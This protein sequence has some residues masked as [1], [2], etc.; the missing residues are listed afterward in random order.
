MINH[1]LYIGWQNSYLLSHPNATLAPQA[2]QAK[3]SGEILNY[4][5]QAQQARLSGQIEL[6]AESLFLHPKVIS[7]LAP[8]SHQLLLILPGQEFSKLSAMVQLVLNSFP[9]IWTTRRDHWRRWRSSTGHTWQQ[10]ETRS[11]SRARTV[12][13]STYSGEIVILKS[14]TDCYHF[15]FRP[16]NISLETAQPNAGKGKQSKLW[17]YFS[18]ILISTICKTMLLQ[19]QFGIFIILC[20]I[21]NLASKSVSRR[22]TWTFDKTLPVKS[23]SESWGCEAGDIS[24]LAVLVFVHGESWSWGSSALYDARI[25]ATLG[26][27]IVVTFNYRL[28]VFG[29]LFKNI[30]FPVKELLPTN[31][32]RIF[33][34]Y[35]K[36]RLTVSSALTDIIFI[37]NIFVACL[38][39]N[40]FFQVFSTRIRLL[41]PRDPLLTMGWWTRWRPCSGWWRISSSLAE[42]AAG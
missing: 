13:T 5:T 42:T 10:W 31:N 17:K 29:E 34:E 4:M 25:L 19:I 24:E 16:S 20:L 11:L 30:Q 1:I 33:Q 28:G 26:R 8:D 2:R 3:A 37:K 41:W 23:Y 21:E 15:V 39:K 14:L 9:K 6:L 18:T 38:M 27:I 40:I 35:C 7:L 36:H 22:A 12:S 32:K